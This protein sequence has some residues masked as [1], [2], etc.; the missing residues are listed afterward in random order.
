MINASLETLNALLRDAPRDLINILM[1]PDGIAQSR[2]YATDIRGLKSRSLS[3]IS[4]ATTKTLDESA[5]IDSE[6]AEITT[7]IDKWMG[8]AN[9]V[10][11]ISAKSL[12]NLSLQCS[13]EKSE[14][15]D[16]VDSCICSNLYIGSVE[17]SEFDIASKQVEDMDTSADILSSERSSPKEISTIELSDIKYEDVDVGTFTDKAVALEYCCRIIAK[18]FLLT[19]HSSNI[20]PDKIVR[21]SVKSS[22]LTCISSIVQYFPE[23]ML[24]YLNKNC[25]K[26][27][28]AKNVD[29]K[30]KMSDIL[31]FSEHLDPQLRGNVTFLV[32]NL[33]QAVLIYAQGDYD[34]WLTENGHDER[35]I[36]DNLMNMLIRVSYCQ[37]FDLEVGFKP[38]L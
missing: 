15:A 20:I 24:M 19:G 33:V 31:L 30:Q 12:S 4:I 34:S 18:S 26:N 29:S 3:Q 8:D 6:L 1:S 16:N 10:E 23:V 7:N 9:T 35:L 28:D 2:I 36:L 25:A 14:A 13:E 27:V 32:G 38:N 17:N 37:E 5:M 11:N 22:A 21:I